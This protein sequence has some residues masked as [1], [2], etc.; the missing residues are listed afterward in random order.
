MTA[1]AERDAAEIRSWLDGV[2]P[3][4]V[5]TE[6]SEIR[7]SDA[8]VADARLLPQRATAGRR[9]EFGA[10]RRLARAALLRL[11]RTARHL[12]PDPDRVPIWPDGVTGSI[13][14]SNRICAVQLASRRAV[15]ALGLDLE[16]AGALDDALAATVRRAGDAA[17]DGQ[18]SAMGVE[19]GLATFAIKEAFFK[20]YF[21]VTRYWCDFLDVELSPTPDAHT[22]VAH[23]VDPGA[24]PVLS[25]RQ[26][27]V[28]V[29]SAGG[30]IVCA[31]YLTN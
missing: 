29:G 21:P 4:G 12:L 27:P 6:V 13:S 24:P 2:A 3:L 25:V 15:P 26:L 17:C 28:H 23:L 22:I 5:V 14:H 19:P 7:A 16:P 20:A 18:L 9:A 8:A 31:A 1:I 30:H 11:G 10:G